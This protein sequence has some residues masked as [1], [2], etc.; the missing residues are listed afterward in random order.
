MNKYVI[1]SMIVSIMALLLL[2]VGCSKG[3]SGTQP[4]TAPSPLQGA[5]TADTTGD[6]DQSETLGVSIVGAQGFTPEVVTVRIGNYVQWKNEDPKSKAVVLTFQKGT[7]RQ[8]F[9]SN[10]LKVGDTYEHYFD[11]VGTYSYW[12]TGY[13]VKGTVEV[14]E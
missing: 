5:V 13:G 11:E 3:S 6:Y 1:V 12:T 9:N 10:L 2:V 14:T 4:A 8:L 7:T